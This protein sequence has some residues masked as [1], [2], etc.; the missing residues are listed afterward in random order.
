VRHLGLF[1]A[2]GAVVVLLSFVLCACG[3]GRSVVAIQPPPA[4]IATP[5]AQAFK[6]VRSV[7]ARRFEAHPRDSDIPSLN[8]ADVV[9]AALTA[10]AL[11][12]KRGSFG[13]ARGDIMLPEDSPVTAL[14]AEC[15]RSALAS[16]GGVLVAE[17][18]PRFAGARPLELTVERMWS[19]FR[20]GAFQVA[21]EFD[22]SVLI[23]GALPGFEQGV[24]V[25]GHSTYRA[26]MVN[27]TR[28]QRTVQEGVQLLTDNMAGALRPAI[29]QL[30]A[31]VTGGEAPPT[32]A[33]PS[34]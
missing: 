34:P 23:R 11:G 7:D 1:A 20:P 22:A 3:A 24:S 5:T 10:R 8:D 28:W 2:R 21:V 32:P 18:D 12:R 15:M 29:A 17:N 4:G 19:W 14:V 33:A 26:A 27:E 6:L 30:A 31:P 13:K 16:A 25:N 9:N